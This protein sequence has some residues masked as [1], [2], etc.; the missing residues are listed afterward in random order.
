M[1]TQ[2]E[3]IGGTVSLTLTRTDAWGDEYEASCSCHPLWGFACRMAPAGKGA[4]AALATAGFHHE[5]E[6][7]H[8]P[9][10]PLA[11]QWPTITEITWDGKP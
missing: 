6:H 4:D 10:A 11:P 9:D 3:V 8:L 7:G 2:V 1:G 5:A